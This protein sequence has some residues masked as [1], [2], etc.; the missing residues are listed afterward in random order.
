MLSYF[1]GG[2]LADRFRAHFLLPVALLLTALGGLYFATLPSRTGLLVLHVYWGITTVLLFWGALIRATRDDASESRQ[3]CAFGI[4]EGGRGLLAASVA[5]AGLLVLDAGTGTV[6][7][8][9]LRRERLRDI[10]LMYTCVT[11][12]VG[13]LCWWGLR[14]LPQAL[15]SGP[16]ASG[17]PDGEI[18]AT[19]SLR[20]S[21]RPLRRHL[22][23]ALIIAS[24]Y[25]GYKGLDFAS[26]FATQVFGEGE[27]DGAAWAT[28]TVWLRA[29]SAL[30]AGLLADRFG[31]RKL[32]MAS[33]LALAVIYLFSTANLTTAS[34]PNLALL[35]INVLGS[36]I[37]LYALRSLYF[38]LLAETG[39]KRSHT[40]TAVGVVSVLGYT[41]DF[42][43]PALA[44]TI[45]ESGSEPQS[46]YATFYLLLGALSL[47]GAWASYALRATPS[48]RQDRRLRRHTLEGPL[49]VTR[50][51]PP[52]P[53]SQ[54]TSKEAL[55]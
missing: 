47:V 10:I 7:N 9:A 44:G 49:S 1:P 39:V 6:L 34:S 2:L 53:P 21:R 46:A 37:L 4:L 3:G 40:G 29:P 28:W 55:R 24:A 54:F 16:V 41:P 31:A 15:E 27:V 14:Q 52:Q 51:N 48:N 19:T 8:E 17:G 5:T 30:G 12:G 33:F 18:A 45:L 23:H 13:V 36:S 32:T 11:A 35:A 50:E 43:F 22:I 38:A 26:T 25:C 20:D 42:F